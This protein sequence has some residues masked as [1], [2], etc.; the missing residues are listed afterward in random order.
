MTS[1]A[2]PS[3]AAN[4]GAAQTFPEWLA[5]RAARQGDAVALRYKRRG[6]WHQESWRELEADVAALA[7]GLSA[8]GFAP[9]DRLLV[10]AGP[11]PTV[12]RVALAVLRL[13]GALLCGVPGGSGLGASDEIRFALAEDDAARARIGAAR[14]AVGAGALELGIVLDGEDAVDASSAWLSLD[15]LREVDDTASP[16]PPLP[17]PGTEG[18]VGLSA[19]ASLTQGAWLQSAQELLAAAGI[20]AGKRVFASRSLGSLAL[21]AQLASLLG[22]WVVSGFALSFGETAATEDYDRREIGPHVVFGSE[23]GYAALVARTRQALPSGHGLEARWISRSLDG[24]GGPRALL[25]RFLVR[26]LREVVGLGHLERAVAVGGAGAAAAGFERLFGIAP[27][28]WH[29]S[30]GV[31]STVGTLA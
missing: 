21:P 18:L 26:R 23:D 19:R 27:F 1:L 20:D 24:G 2:S 28:A 29:A 14:E 8:R 13:G 25:R 7:R 10:D 4:T 15:A 22:A 16:L 17:S 9:G 5:A 6:L 12:F 30:A 3:S 31:P 11:G